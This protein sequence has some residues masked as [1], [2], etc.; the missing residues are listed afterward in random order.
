MK[1]RIVIERR[2]HGRK[3][4]GC[5]QGRSYRGVDTTPG[6]GYHGDEDSD[7]E[8]K[9]KKKREGEKRERDLVS[10]P[11]ALVTPR[12]RKTP[13]RRKESGEG[14]YRVEETEGPGLIT[15]SSSSKTKKSPEGKK[16]ATV[17]GNSSN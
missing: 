6:D 12:I 10:A 13:R 7:I 8:R 17:W 3:T 11:T 1:T 2:A 16:N 15:S 9:T 14:N 4:R 5:F